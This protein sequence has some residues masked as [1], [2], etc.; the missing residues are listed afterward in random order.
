MSQ[1]FHFVNDASFHS[2]TII[3]PQKSG[4]IA[5]SFYFLSNCEQAPQRSSSLISEFMVPSPMSCSHWTP[6]KSIICWRK[7]TFCQSYQAFQ[8][9][10]G[11]PGSV[12]G[13]ALPLHLVVPEEN[14]ITLIRQCGLQI[15]NEAEIG[16][17]LL[18]APELLWFAWITC[19]YQV[20]GQ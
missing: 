8:Q 10:D 2:T 20:L 5:P 11:C 19:I 16:F 12:P 1:R 13:I 7:S 3:R 9:A 18:H 6:N 4:F 14:L 15:P 17:H